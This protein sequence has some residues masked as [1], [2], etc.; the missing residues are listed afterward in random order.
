MLR[1]VL[2]RLPLGF[3]VACTAAC[4][5]IANFRPASGLMPDRSLEV[6]TGV[7]RVSPRPYVDEE[8]ATAGQVWVTGEVGDHR[9]ALSAVSAFDDDAIGVGGA[10]RVNAIRA[11]RFAGGVEAEL[12]YGWFS[13]SL[14]MALRLVDQ[15]FFYVGPR[16]FNWSLDPGFGIPVGLSVRVYDGF[17]LRAEW[18]R[19]WQGF[20]YYNRRD[21]L[22]AAAAYQF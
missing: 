9:M 1:L 3:L 15:S 19:S 17:I 13:L 22:G 8:P 6:G 4:G 11:D 20:K 7:A 21:H 12:G 5:P 2:R 14:P 10:L 16:L 18:Q